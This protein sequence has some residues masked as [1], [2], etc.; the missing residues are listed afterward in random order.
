[1]IKNIGDALLFYFPDMLHNDARYFENVVN[2]CMKM[3]DSHEKIN[4]EMDVK[5]L[6]SCSYRISAVYGPV[7]IAQM[8]TSTVADIFGSTV[9]ICTKINS[10][11]Q[12]NGF[13][14]DGDLYDHVKLSSRF[15]FKEIDNYP[16]DDNTK[17][18]VYSVKYRSR[19]K[20]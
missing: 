17:I 9:N 11:A 3:I 13:V 8:S 2:C 5:G 6:S 1:V 18:S 14:I 20:K 19:A 12:P 16:L 4:D 15:K 10:L 7:M